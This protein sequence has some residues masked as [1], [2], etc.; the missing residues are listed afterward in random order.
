[1]DRR[2]VEFFVQLVSEESKSL[3]NGE[4]QFTFVASSGDGNEY[5]VQV[6][7][8]GKSPAHNFIGALHAA[9]S[10]LAKACGG[11]IGAAELVDKARMH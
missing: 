10:T 6:T 7:G 2:R 9:A 1:M 5:A 4:E 11:S 3:P 8:P